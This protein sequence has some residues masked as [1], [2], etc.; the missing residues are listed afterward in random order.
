MNKGLQNRVLITGINGFT[1]I[2]L[3]Q[4]LQ[5]EGFDIYGTVVNTPI[6]KKHFQCDIRQK[7]QIDRVIESVKPDYLIHIAAI[8][9]PGEE[10]AALIY[11]VN[12][13][14]TENILK[15]L[16]D[17][18]I[19]P[20]K[21]ILASSANIYGSQ[22]AE[23]LDE[24]MCPKPVNHYG[25]SKLAME[26]LAANYFDRFDTII[27]RPFNYT[28]PGQDSH[29]LIPKIISHFKEKKRVIELGNLNVAREFNDIDYIVDIYYKLLL[30][31]TKSIAVNLSS[32]H[33]VK[34]LD[35]IEMMN[36]IAGYTIEVKVNPLF[37]REN[38]IPSLSG[39]T[40]LLETLIELENRDTL[41]KTLQTMY[42]AP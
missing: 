4:R 13:I 36:E 42:D 34:L 35:V 1:G 32:N 24:T 15:S 41:H 17:K 30:S 11:D 7:E 29:F 40:D 12:T 22:G 26:H 14:G 21:I 37:V 18:Q 39:S 19:T 33:P 28:G 27:T 2:H 8:S 6:S 9:F 10:N 31:N 20:K 3:E 5:K 38:E 25:C 23:V 16:A